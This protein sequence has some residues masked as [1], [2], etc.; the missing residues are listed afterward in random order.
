MIL[1]SLAGSP[2]LSSGRAPAVSWASTFGKANAGS[3]KH[4]SIVAAVVFAV[5][6]LGDACA[7][8]AG[9]RERM[10][11]MLSSIRNEMSE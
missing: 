5:H 2:S 3:L 1:W 8:P 11:L 6:L 4:L 7:R 9:Q 10:M